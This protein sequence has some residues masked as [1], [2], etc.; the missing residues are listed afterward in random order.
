MSDLLRKLLAGLSSAPDRPTIALLSD[1]GLRDS[2]VGVVKAVIV[3]INPQARLIDVTHEIPGH[4]I[5][6]GAY[7]LWSSYRFF[8][9]GTIFLAVVDPGVGT[10]RAIL[11][12]QTID[13]T[14]LVPDNGILDLVRAEGRVNSVHA[15]Q[16]SEP[17]QKWKRYV[18]GESSRTFHGR[19]VFAPVAAHLSLGV[20]PEQ[21][22]DARPLPSPSLGFCDPSLG[23]GNPCVLHIDT[24]GNIITNIRS[25]GA[26]KLRG[27]SLGRRKVTGWIATYEEGHSEK[28]RLI[29]GSS[30]L[31]EVV[32]RG[33]SAAKALKA[34]LGTPIR[35]EAS[36]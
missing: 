35:L 10:D 11:I 9:Q 16:T 25:A 32:V 36:R 19:D 22:G 7:A 21:I 6:E 2:Y 29:A 20:R 30:G 18:R 23:A 31:V 8:P 14:F 34:D 24:F 33:G 15:F 28:A 1:F 27:L 17:G 4:N 3:G 13:H 5:R 26:E 12:A